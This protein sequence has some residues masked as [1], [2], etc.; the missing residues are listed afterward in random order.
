MD[1]ADRLFDIRQNGFN[2][3]T[4]DTILDKT[5]LKAFPCDKLNVTKMM[6]SV[7]D[8]V[9]KMVGKGEI[10]CTSN[11]S[12]SHNVFGKRFLSQTRH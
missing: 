10:A 8:R 3:F 5:K 2:P 7:S 9:E 12:L 1:L 4:H 6:I 11:Y